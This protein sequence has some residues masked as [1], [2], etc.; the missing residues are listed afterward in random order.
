MHIS[1]NSDHTENFEVEEVSGHVGLKEVG[2]LEND[3]IIRL[4]SGSNRNGRENYLQ[5][6]EGIEVS[7]DPRRL[8]PLAKSTA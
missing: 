3:Y 2:R 5:Y 6:F 8:S 1:L 4:V 7:E